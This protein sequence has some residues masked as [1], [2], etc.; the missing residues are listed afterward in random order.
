MLVVR[1]CFEQAVVVPSSSSASGDA[2]QGLSQLH[3]TYL[4]SN[5][6]VPPFS[7]WDLRV[8]PA[9]VVQSPLQRTGHPGED[10]PASTP[11]RLPGISLQQTCPPLELDTGESLR[12]SSPSTQAS[13]NGWFMQLNS[14]G[15]SKPTHTL[16]PNCLLGA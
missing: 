6:G 5:H 16:T 14:A 8:G 10:T 12:D 7:L 13:R 2:S 15:V 3:R 11:E 1:F 9:V 4:A